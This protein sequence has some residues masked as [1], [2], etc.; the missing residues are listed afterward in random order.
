MPGPPPNRKAQTRRRN[1]ST[2][3]VVTA[4]STGEVVGYD[5]GGEH[6]DQG[7]RWWE[8]LRTSGQAQFYETSDWAHAELVVL[9]IDTFVK[10]PTAMMLA[11]I[12]Q[13]S[14]VLLVTEGDRRRAR[15]ELEKAP[16]PEA[17]SPDVSELAEWRTRLSS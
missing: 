10:K 2:I 11:S 9:A 14:S 12:N 15:V 16:V 1:K 7:H 13:M 6:S 5:L 3:P 8:A 4:A 17:E